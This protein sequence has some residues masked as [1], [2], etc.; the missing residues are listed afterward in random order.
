MDM[1]YSELKHKINLLELNEV[2][3]ME[4]IANYRNED[5]IDILND[6]IVEYN[7]KNKKDYQKAIDAFWEA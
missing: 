2:Q 4:M 5:V 7:T 1:T 6:F 3:K